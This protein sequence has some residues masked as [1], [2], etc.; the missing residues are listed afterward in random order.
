MEKN[1][2]FPERNIRNILFFYIYFYQIFFSLKDQ[3][4]CIKKGKLATWGF[5][6]SLITNTISYFRNWL[7]QDGGSKMA[8]PIC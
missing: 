1:I 2:F 4:F 3:K 5:T 7:I 8:N 6:G